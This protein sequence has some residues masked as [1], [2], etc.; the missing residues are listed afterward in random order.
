[1]LSVVAVTAGSVQIHVGGANG[2]T[3]AYVTSGC[4][5]VGLCVA[6]SA[7]LA[8]EG[9]YANVLFGGLSPTSLAPSSPTLTDSNSGVIFSRISDSASPG[10]NTWD[11]PLST[12]GT[13]PVTSQMTV[14]IGVYGVSDVWTTLNDI[15]STQNTDATLAFNFGL[16]SNATALDSVMVILNNTNSTNGAA[17]VRDGCENGNCTATGAV[18]SLLATTSL[19]D[20][21]AAPATMT[22]DAN[23]V[24]T[25][26]NSPLCLQP[27]G[28]LIPALIVR[29]PPL[30]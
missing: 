19:E 28:V 9:T 13:A 15:A 8:R 3:Q 22:V 21:N 18:G 7:G 20:T 26:S 11:I 2:L 24:Y 16:T 17:Q 10:S 27:Q 23:N 30:P 6:G 1:V 25:D 4:S 29:L 12:G 5:A 14:P